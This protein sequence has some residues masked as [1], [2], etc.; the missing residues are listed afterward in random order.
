MFILNNLCKYVKCKTGFPLATFNSQSTFFNHFFCLMIA[1][2]A[3]VRGLES[4]LKE[5]FMELGTILYSILQLFF[6]RFLQHN[7]LATVNKK[8]LKGMTSLRIL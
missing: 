5:T 4:K 8:W 7:Q 6:F 3:S 1:R 2:N